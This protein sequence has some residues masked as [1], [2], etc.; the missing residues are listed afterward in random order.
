VLLSVGG[1]ASA[2]AG[3]KKTPFERGTE[4]LRN[5]DLDTAITELTTAV[6]E[7]QNHAEAYNNR[8]L[9]YLQQ[10]DLNNAE[11][12]FLAATNLDST[13]GRAW[14]NLANVYYNREE[15]TQAQTY[16]NQAL[17]TSGGEDEPFHADVYNNL[18]II[19]ERLGNQS[20]ALAAYNDA[21]RVKDTLNLEYTAA[22]YNRGNLYYD[23]KRYNE[24][25]ADYGVT[26]TFYAGTPGTDTAHL[27]DA[28]Y[29]RGLSY[30][31]LYNYSQAI[32]DY[33]R[34][35][36]IRPD[37]VWAHYSKGYTHFM[38]GE[39]QTALDCYDQVLALQSVHPNHPAYAWNYLA[40]ALAYQNR[41]Q[42]GDDIRYL[43][44]L[45]KSCDLGNDSACALLK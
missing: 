27:A 36:E 23:Q 20:S 25:I 30:Y 37:F 18:G 9:A 43:E 26:I 5:G 22:Y 10:G 14:N 40:M 21:I 19:H 4:A 38:R 17:A 44:S 34:A 16:Y 15:Y 33:D 41:G 28:Y 6:A 11:Q 35:I 24:A 42:S 45:T 3:E 2:H 32:T 8:G 12:D 7:D 1:G 31:N 13:N 29:N 39:Y